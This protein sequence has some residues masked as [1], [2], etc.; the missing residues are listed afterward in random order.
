MGA[1]PT[2]NKL[3]VTGNQ[4]HKSSKGKFHRRQIVIDIG[5]VKLDVVYDRDLRQ[6]V[7][8]LRTLV[9]IG[10]VV[11]VAFNDEV[12]AISNSKTYAEVLSD[13]ANKES[14][15]KA[16]LI[17]HPGGDA[18]SC[19]LAMGP[20]DNQRA[21]AANEFLLY[22]FSLRAIEQLAIEGRFHFRVPARN[23]VADNNAIRLRLQMF[24]FVA[25]HNG[26]T[27]RGEHRGHWW[28]NVLVGASDFMTAS[29]QHSRQS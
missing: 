6:V 21:A 16:A 7:H 15:I 11:F 22:N 5:M 12:I 24:C 2:D 8:K 1:I 29:L 13:A 25:L 14:W 27:E 4:I 9:E 18:R 19:S 10:R 23:S 28:I 3:A 20:G 26:N 17:Q